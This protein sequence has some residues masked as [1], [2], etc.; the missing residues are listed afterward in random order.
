MRTHDFLWLQYRREKQ[1]TELF[2]AFFCE[3]KYTVCSSRGEQDY[4]EIY[5]SINPVYLCTE[6]IEKNRD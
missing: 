3:F 6:V 5:F 1:I 2:L 4:D